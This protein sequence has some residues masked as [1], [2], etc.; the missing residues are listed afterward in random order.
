MKIA[1]IGSGAVG[2]VLGGYLAKNGNDIT[3]IT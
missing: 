2:C 1:I 3:L